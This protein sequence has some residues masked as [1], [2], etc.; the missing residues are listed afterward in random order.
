[1]FEN[2]PTVSSVERQQVLAALERLQSKLVQREEWTHSDNMRNLRETLQSPLFNH[3]LT[4]HHSIKQLRHQLNGSPGDPLT[5]FSFSQKGQLIFN[6]VTN[7]SAP[8]TLQAPPPSFDLQK[9]IHSNAKGRVTELLRLSRPP[10]GGLGFSVVGL[11]PGGSSSQGVFVKHIQPGGV[12]H[13]AGLQERDE[14]LVI[15]GRALEPGVSQQEALSLLQRGDSV[16]LVIA[17]ERALNT[18]SER[19]VKAPPLTPHID[20]DLWGHVEQIELENDGSGLG[21][22]IVGGK[23]GIVVRTLLP[24]SVAHRDGRLRTGDHLLSIGG[25][26]TVDLGSE[27]VVRALQACGNRVSMVIAR[28]YRGQRAAGPPPPPDSAPVS[29]PAPP[30]PPDSAPVSAPAPPPPR[31]QPQRRVSKTPNLDGYE[32]HEVSLTKKQGQSLGISIIGYN[33]LTS[34]DAVGVFVKSVVPGSAADQNGNIRVHDRIIA[35]DGVS[36]HGRTNNEVLE[37]M[38]QTGQTVVLTVVR[39]KRALERSLD[40]VERAESRVSLRRSVELRSRSARSRERGASE[41]ELRAKWEQALGPKYQVLVVNLDPVIEDDE[42]LQ[43]S[44]KLLPVHTVRLGVELDSFD[45]H[46]YIS[47][48]V[49][50]G[51]VDKHGQLRPEDE[52]LEVNEVQVYGK[53]R[54]EVISFLKEVPPPFTL[55]CCRHPSLDQED[56]ALD[57]DSDPETEPAP[58][59]QAQS[60]TKSEP[61]PRIREGASLEEIELKLS[62]LLC[63]IEPRGKRD[64]SSPE[65]EEDSGPASEDGAEEEDSEEDGELAM[66][67]PEIQTI[68]LT[69]D[70]DKG[71]GFSILDYQDPLDPGRCVMVVRSLVVGGAA[72]HSGRVLPGDQVVWVNSTQLSDLSLSEAVEVLKAAPVGD[73]RLGVRKPLVE[74]AEPRGDSVRSATKLSL[75]EAQL[76]S[77]LEGEEDNAPEL[78]LDGGL[79]RYSSLS[80][81]VTSDL[82][83]EGEGREM[84]VDEEQEVTRSRSRDEEEEEEEEEDEVRERRGPPPSWD[85]WRRSLGR[86]SSDQTSDLKQEVTEAQD[87][88]PVTSDPESAASAAKTTPGLS[89]RDSEADSELTLTDTDT[90]S[91]RVVN[92]ERRRRRGQA[93]TYPPIRGGHSDL[94]E[95]EEGEG[96]ETPAFSHWGPPRRVE[97]SV[98]PGQSLGLSIVGGRHVIKRLRNG[99]ELKGIFIKQVLPHSPAAQTDSLKTGDKILE[100]NGA[101]LRS[102]SHEEAVEAIKSAQSPVLFV[103]QSLSNTPRPVSLLASSYSKHRSKRSP[104]PNA[105]VPT[106]PVRE[107]PPYRP[108]SQSE[109]GSDLDQAKGPV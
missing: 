23:S 4:L 109:T 35:L 29:A 103:V 104:S 11:N 6:S 18:S 97:V 26:S 13:S 88:P 19:A 38:K 69:K 24:N 22:G 57:R 70:Q 5:D 91:V 41:A 92:A 58:E 68:H 102:A 16:E 84:A 95:R 96:E 36:L 21:F 100:V 10:S 28:D 71:L 7:H 94:P 9:W 77:D 2:I 14:I 55:V 78:I 25:V 32:I 12:A 17:R 34:Q 67:S 99:E 101:D 59:Y 107:P 90:E 47:S 31:N 43:R 79:P 81:H 20:T 108:P 83:P 49:P 72:E 74:A 73:V 45:G 60:E 54:R 51:P 40:K 46:H 75:E 98:A 48:V 82:S 85:E 39:K 27:Q 89:S 37:V 53:S 15:N 56:P 62:S 61:G 63:P 64:G 8:N 44:S 66:W 52:L 1:M 87:D 33:P 76:L 50:E 42:E 65:P 30:M 3:I 106:L 80:T 105:A 93:G 86:I